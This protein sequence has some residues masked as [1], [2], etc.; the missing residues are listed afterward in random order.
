[1]IL[2]QILCRGISVIPKTNNPR[3][4][5]EN[6]DVLFDIQEED[7]KMID[8]L[9]GERGELGV[10]NLVMEDYLGFNV[11]NEEKDEP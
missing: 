8:S 9:V 1:M 5:D 6:L 10:R 2:C 4:I 3:R 7:F 11:F